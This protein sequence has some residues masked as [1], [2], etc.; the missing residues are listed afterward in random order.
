MYAFNLP[1]IYS[2]LALGKIRKSNSNH[3]LLKRSGFSGLFFSL[4]H[5]PYLFVIH[6]EHSFVSKCNF[7]QKPFFVAQQWTEAIQ[8]CFH[9]IELPNVEFQFEVILTITKCFS[10]SFVAHLSP[11][12][13]T[14]IHNVQFVVC[15]VGYTLNL[16]ALSL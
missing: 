4:P 1:S 12:T 5:I 2:H 10:L 11:C 7:H 3:F 9:Y 13:H 8:N 16:D 6:S 15:A 14:L